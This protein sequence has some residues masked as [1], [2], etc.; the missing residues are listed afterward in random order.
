M[1]LLVS[2][3]VLSKKTF[4]RGG[5][6]GMGWI[7]ALSHGGTGKKM[8]TFLVL[9]LLPSGLWDKLPQPSLPQSP[10]PQNR[11]GCTWPPARVPMS[12]TDG[13]AL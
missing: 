13:E 7:M 12:E 1:G 5:G 6:S 2:I 11:G 4:G 10:Q 9:L 3:L 8:G